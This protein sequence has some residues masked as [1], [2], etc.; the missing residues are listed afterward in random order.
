LP[1]WAAQGRHRLDNE[2]HRSCGQRANP[3]NN[4]AYG[5]R[6]RRRS[7]RL[8]HREKPACRSAP[9]GGL[10]S[11]S[12]RSWKFSCVSL[13]NSCAL[14]THAPATTPPEEKPTAPSS[15]G[16]TTGAVTVTAPATRRTV[17]ARA[18]STEGRLGGLKATNQ[19]QGGPSC[20]YVVEGKMWM[21]GDAVA[22]SSLLILRNRRPWFAR[23]DSL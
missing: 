12:E 7:S 18:R 2:G 9:D 5:R 21:G 6:R 13:G 10:R 22:S 16:T 15:A 8:Q 17:P 19:Q 20:V 11:C 14:R 4:L 1:S 3:C 23:C